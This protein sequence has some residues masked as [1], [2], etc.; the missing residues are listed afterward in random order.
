[1]KDTQKIKLF[2]YL[3][4]I[5]DYWCDEPDLTTR[6]AVECM[7]LN[8]MK[9]FDGTSYVNNFNTYS[10]IDDETDEEYT[11][12]CLF[13]AFCEEKTNNHF[14]EA[15]RDITEF[16]INFSNY[17]KE[18]INE[19][20]MDNPFS[21]NYSPTLPKEVVITSVINSILDIFDGNSKWCSYRDCKIIENETGEYFLYADLRECYC[22]QHG[23]E[24][25]Y[26]F[27]LD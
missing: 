16:W 25:D 18:G 9:L 27:D 2:D 8:F 23:M 14:V 12:E 24:D 19:E 21:D 6:E 10:I 22:K 13:D 1:M 15:V 3:D 17:S 26:D 5:K 4:A 7:V 11:A 20:E